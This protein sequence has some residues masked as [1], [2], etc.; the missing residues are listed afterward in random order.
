MSTISAASG[1]I[2]VQGIVSQLMQI[3]RQPLQAIQKNLSGIQAR[4][5]AF[6]KL[7]SA[8]AS[9]QDAARALTRSATWQASTAGSSDAAAVKATAGSGAI[10]G[11]Y[12]IEV[13]Q[14]ARRQTVA[15]GAYADG[16]AVVGEG[17]LRIRM[18]ALDA[19]GTS[20]TPDAARPEVA[21]TIAA[22]STLA[23]VRDAINAAGAGVTASLVAD[24]SGQRL[25]LRSTDSGAAQAFSVA[26]DD[27]DGA[28][29]DASG[30]SA[31]AF[32]P[33]AAAG[34][35]RNLSLTQ[36]AQDALV[37]VNGLQVSSPSNRLTGVIEN[38]T[39]ELGRV[40]T[41]PVEVTVGSDSASL[42]GSLD[43]FVKSWNDLNKLLAD[44]V[45]YDPDTKTAGPLQGDQTVVRVQ[46]QL[47]EILR[48]TV[49]SGS[50]NSLSA[51][52]IEVQRDGSLA[53]NAAR[54]DAAL[55][56]PSAVQAFF[57]QSGA[58]ASDDGLA[59]RLVTRLDAMLATDGVLTG[60]TD[61]LHAREKAAGQQQERLE[62]RLNEIQK[63]L[64]RQYTALDAN[65]AQMT[66][67]LASVQSLLDS[68]ASSKG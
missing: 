59:K 10:A 38:V 47:R 4:L 5:S 28:S 52:G 39:L 62:A 67:S 11:G 18:G 55:A 46:Q 3:E 14:L 68:N 64:L 44:Q 33:A 41:S 43:A 7:Q 12:S 15:S 25:M 57:A 16:A 48:G 40:T 34:A 22:G 23:Q 53:T 49:G 19:T 61:S 45:R 1:G 50:P 36:S 21:V 30:L 56:D 60:A 58:T 65:L 26:V 17:T 42:R 29:Q 24:G 8:L 54:L 37:T 35:G 63:R 13:A 6:G 2:D 9:F 20:F 32:D 66:S 51:L 27:A 31:L